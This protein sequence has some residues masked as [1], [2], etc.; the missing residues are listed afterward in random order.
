MQKIR[1]LHEKNVQTWHD[2]R[3]K[4]I[5]EGFYCKVCGKNTNCRL[6]DESICIL[7]RTWQTL[8]RRILNFNHRLKKLIHHSVKVRLNSPHRARAHYG[9][10][11]GNKYHLHKVW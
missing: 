11:Y 3:C 5:N 8:Y 10:K 2:D 7:C 6:N 4:I 9:N 1:G